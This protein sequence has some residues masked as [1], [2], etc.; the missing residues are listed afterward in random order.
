MQWKV[1]K[2][3][4]T[5]RPGISHS[6]ASW[7][8]S[9][10]SWLTQTTRVGLM[11]GMTYTEMAAEGRCVGIGSG[12]ASG[13]LGTLAR[14]RHCP[15]EFS[16]CAVRDASKG[17]TMSSRRHSTRSEPSAPSSGSTPERPSESLCRCPDWRRYPFSHNWV[18]KLERLA[19]MRFR[20]TY[21][22]L[23]LYE[24]RCSGMTETR[25]E[26]EH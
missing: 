17:G 4:S 6:R 7:T 10:T 5:R 19:N 11:L 16:L 26:H 1:S 25:C 2:S 8:T 24:F 3:I 23:P 20:C 21:C 22:H 14:V 9:H 18:R 12:R 13:K 15:A